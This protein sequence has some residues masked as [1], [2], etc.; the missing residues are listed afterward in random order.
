[1]KSRVKNQILGQYALF[2][3]KFFD[4]PLVCQ[5]D[6][7]DFIDSIYK[8]NVLRLKIFYPLLL[9][10]YL[11][12]ISVDIWAYFQNSAGLGHYYLYIVSFQ[13]FAL[14]SL[15]LV[16]P[17]SLFKK[18]FIDQ[19]FYAEQRK[20]LIHFIAFLIPLQCSAVAIV[21]LYMTGLINAHFLGILSVTVVFILPNSIAF[22]LFSIVQLFFFGGL[23]YV[24]PSFNSFVNH[25]M[26]STILFIVALFVS[27]IMFYGRL[28]NFTNQKNLEKNNKN[29]ETQVQVRSEQLAEN[30]QMA[31]LGMQ[32]AEIVHNLKNPLSIIR[33]YS[34]F[35]TDRYP[36]DKFISNIVEASDRLEGIVCTILQNTAKK[37]SDRQAD[38]SF[39]DLIQDEMKMLKA[40][41][42]FFKHRVELE[43]DLQAPVSVNGYP[44]QI[45][46][47]LD[48]LFKNA[49]DA[50]FQS[51][52]KKL[53]VKTFVDQKNIHIWIQ[54]SGHGIEKD[55][56]ERIFDPFFTTKPSVKR[57]HDEPT[58][59]GLGLPYC[60]RVIELHRGSIHI[61]SQVGVGTKLCLKFPLST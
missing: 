56:L 5:H 14:M 19:D 28:S 26:S 16:A 22:I 2:D 17:F 31:S 9:V 12:I 20:M 11:A 23:F 41:S 61:E 38:F 1:M 25:F 42:T 10:I 6:Y 15:I 54:D 43:M 45:S 3:A 55:Q 18:G 7:A 13:I 29:L 40:S 52:Q 53:F 49:I 33:G 50:M 44:G 39:D 4:R 57:T 8:S 34:V 21:D 47:C 59:T 24:H 51:P 58:G 48:N 30:L 37:T 27:R 36:E 60:K 46:Q 35:L 32:A